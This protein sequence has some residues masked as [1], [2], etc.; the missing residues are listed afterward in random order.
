[1]FVIELLDTTYKDHI[2]F[3]HNYAAN[4]FNEYADAIFNKGAHMHNV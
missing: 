2:K 3:S 1:M 4:N